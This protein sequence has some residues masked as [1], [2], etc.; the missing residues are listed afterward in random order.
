MSSVPTTTERD[1]PMGDALRTEFG[2][3]TWEVGVDIAPGVYV[4]DSP[5]GG[6]WTRL[7]DLAGDGEEL[8]S[9]Y[10]QN[11]GR[12]LVEIR[13]TDLAFKS[14]GCGTRRRRR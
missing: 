10:L 14:E 13:P 5:P 6:S 8:A 11:G 1:E 7:Q 4:A 3:G 12:M 2:D 9:D